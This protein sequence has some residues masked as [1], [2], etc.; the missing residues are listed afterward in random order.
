MNFYLHDPI[1]W[2]QQEYFLSSPLLPPQINRSQNIVKQ[3]SS[4][5]NHSVKFYLKVANKL[6]RMGG[7]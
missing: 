3:L 7:S 1:K 2:T 4:Y 5:V 6:V